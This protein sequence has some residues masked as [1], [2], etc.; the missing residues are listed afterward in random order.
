MA[1][2]IHVEWQGFGLACVVLA[3]GA[4]TTAFATGC[5]FATTFTARGVVADFA[6]A[7]GT[8]FVAA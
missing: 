4:F 6:V 2:C 7:V 5:A 3:R 8:G 1:F